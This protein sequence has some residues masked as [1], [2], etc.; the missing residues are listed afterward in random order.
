MPVRPSPV[1]FRCPRCGWRTTWQ[2]RSDALTLDDL[3]P[4]RCPRCGHRALESHSHPPSLLASL[5][6]LFQRGG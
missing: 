6:R 3:P 4:T 1:D 5:L 2:P